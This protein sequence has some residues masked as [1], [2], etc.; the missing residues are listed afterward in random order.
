MLK[1][2]ALG[3]DDERTDLDQPLN[4]VR[5]NGPLQLI[6]LADDQALSVDAR[7]CV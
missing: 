4:T 2:R 3:E 6:M 1:A 7:Q 5:L